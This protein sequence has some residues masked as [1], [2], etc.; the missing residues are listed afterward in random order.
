[1]RQC[2]FYVYVIG[3]LQSRDDNDDEDNTSDEL[4]ITC[5]EEILNNIVTIY[6]YQLAGTEADNTHK[7]LMQCSS[8]SCSICCRLAADPLR[9]AHRRCRYRS[10]WRPLLPSVNCSWDVCAAAVNTSRVLALSADIDTVLRPPTA[11]IV[12]VGSALALCF[13]N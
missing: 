5:V 13:G 2:I 11:M 12:T 6:Q 4:M 8:S 1:M 10:N 3:A 9:R 7:G